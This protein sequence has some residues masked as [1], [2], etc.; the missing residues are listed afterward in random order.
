MIK[1]KEVKTAKE[2]IGVMACDVLPVAMF[3]QLN[4]SPF[5]TSLTKERISFSI[6]KMARGEKE[7]IMREINFTRMAFPEKIF[8]VRMQ[9]KGNC[10]HIFL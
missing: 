9:K 2:V 1:D 7:V 3:N 4:A 8:M 5:T 6:R 10:F